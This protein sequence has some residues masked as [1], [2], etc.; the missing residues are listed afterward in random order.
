MLLLVKLLAL[1]T[2]FR[3]GWN[4]SAADKHSSLLQTFV[5][6][7]EKS[8]I[9]MYPGDRKQK[10]ESKPS[11]KK[12]ADTRRN[13]IRGKPVPGKFECSGCNQGPIL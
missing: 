12:Y 5:N 9:P 7:E 4:Q 11:K 2:N 10:V 8:F 3:L 13:R 6:K 1:L